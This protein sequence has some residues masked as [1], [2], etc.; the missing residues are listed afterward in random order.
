MSPSLHE[1]I[2]IAL[3]PGRV[4]LVRL[5]RG[6]RPRVTAREIVVCADGAT[7][8]EAALDA[9]REVLRQRQWQGAAASVILSNHFVRYLL[10]PWDEKLSGAEEQLAMVHYAFTQ[11]YG[12]AAS[13]WECRWSEGAPA[14]PCLACAIDRG[15]LT[16]LRECFRETGVRLASVQPYLM[17]A[18]NRWR[19]ELRGDS[20]WFLLAEDGRL[21]LAWLKNDELGW[22]QCQRVDAGWGQALPEILDRALLVAG[23]EAR[24]QVYVHAPG[25]ADGDLMLGGGWAGRLLELGACAGP[26]DASTNDSAYAI[27]M[28]G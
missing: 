25:L 19:R 16:G 24:G 28:A 15:L 21:C 2:Q 10:V 1:R 6:L 12:D 27:A 7:S 3:C 8:W 9:L 17:S 13:S 14:A 23:T 18:L 26:G 5:G 4:I 20:R 22:L 11:A